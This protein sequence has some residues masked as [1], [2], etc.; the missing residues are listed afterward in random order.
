[1][2]LARFEMGFG[3]RSC[4]QTHLVHQLKCGGCWP[5]LVGKEARDDGNTAKAD[6]WCFTDT[7]IGRQRLQ[8]TCTG[9]PSVCAICLR[10]AASPPGKEERDNHNA[11]AAGDGCSWTCRQGR[12]GLDLHRLQLRRR[13]DEL[14]RICILAAEAWTDRPVFGKAADGCRDAACLVEPN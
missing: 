14:W 10:D 12:E 5:S 7:R 8:N 9:A 2:A 4:T 3:F 6:G 11:T 13:I 1:V